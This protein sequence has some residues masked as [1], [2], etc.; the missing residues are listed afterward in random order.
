[1]TSRLGSCPTT[2][3]VGT[4]RIRNTVHSDVRKDH[5]AANLEISFHMA[6]FRS[7][8]WVSRFGSPDVKRRS[9]GKK[10]PHIDILNL[11]NL[12][13]LIDRREIEVR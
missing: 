4:M 2:P 9:C 12:E 8:R 11:F 10:S 7:V 1:M 13:G 3:H 6:A 5:I